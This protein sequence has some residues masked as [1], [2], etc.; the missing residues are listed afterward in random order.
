MSDV[1]EEVRVETDRV[2]IVATLLGA[3]GLLPLI[4]A[5]FVRLAG[6]VYP[7]TPIPIVLG[8]LALSYAALILSFLGGIWWG[9]AATRATPEQMPKLMGIADCLARRRDGMEFPGDRLDHARPDDRTDPAGRSLAGAARDGAGVV[10]EAPAA[11]VARAGC[12][13]AGAGLFAGVN[14]FPFP[15]G[16]GSRGGWRPGDTVVLLAAEAVPRA[17][18]HPQPLPFREGACYAAARSAIRSQISTSAP[19]SSRIISSVWL[20]PGVKRS[21]SVPRGTV[22]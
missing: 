19:V 1:R 6:G 8:G 17:S 18:T 12:A 14:V 21:R 5:L 13:G 4:L 9:V 10:D 16:R 3:A 15:K 20:G 2:P 7:D 11:A 22:G